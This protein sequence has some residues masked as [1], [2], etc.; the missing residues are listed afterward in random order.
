MYIN[1]FVMK[2]SV[3]RKENPET[4]LSRRQGGATKA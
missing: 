2:L 4:Q 3:D 1:L